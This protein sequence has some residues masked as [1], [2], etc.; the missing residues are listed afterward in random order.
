MEVLGE[1]DHSIAHPGPPPADSTVLVSHTGSNYPM[2][3]L[4]PQTLLPWSFH[5]CPDAL[6]AK[7]ITTATSMGSQVNYTQLCLCP[8]GHQMWEISSHL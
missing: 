8:A 1:S 6:P 3:N 2:S 4:L 5:P 7:P